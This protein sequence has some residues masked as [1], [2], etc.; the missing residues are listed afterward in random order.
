M[1]LNAES[2]AK[3]NLKNAN[4][5]LAEAGVM[6]MD[7]LVQILVGFG[8]KNLHKFDKMEEAK[9]IVNKIEL[10]LMVVS[11]HLADGEGC[12]FVK[13]IRNTAAEPNRFAPV[14]MISG[15]TPASMVSKARDCGAHIIVAKPLTPVVLLE[16]ILWV[17]REQRPFVSAPS[18]TGPD[19]R[20]KFEGPPFGVK[21]RRK[22][23]LQGHVKALTKMP[24][25]SQ[26]QIDALMQPRKVSL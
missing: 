10:D 12:D 23:D 16:R 17:A 19:R 3:F 14:I 24:N 4:I 20:F 1:A 13:W 18:Y 8:A 21:G 9:P 26:D 11:T 2:R 6:P 15:H 7:I 22:D 5:L 25:M